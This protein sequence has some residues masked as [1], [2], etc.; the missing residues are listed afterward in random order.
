MGSTKTY[1]RAL[2]WVILLQQAVAQSSCSG[3]YNFGIGIVDV[4]HHRSLRKDTIYGSAAIEVSNGYFDNVT[5]FYGRF[6]NREFDAGILFENIP[7]SKNDTVTI[8]YMFVNN[9]HKSAYQVEQEIENAVLMIASQ[10]VQIASSVVGDSVAEDVGEVVGR[11]IGFVLADIVGWLIGI[12]GG[13]IE[14]LV[15]E[16]CDGYLAGNYHVF[17]GADICNQVVPLSGVDMNE[18]M[19]DQKLFGFIPGLIC[20]IH[21]SL[22]DVN[23]YVE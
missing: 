18:G 11:I 9:G 22:Y 12:V 10:G 1:I 5:Y 13:T 17:S 4:I 8:S 3:T 14:E 2:I 21:T 15:T 23:W 20:S 16:G 6:G 19:P 7:V